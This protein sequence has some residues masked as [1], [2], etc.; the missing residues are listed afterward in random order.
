MTT[1][2][3]THGVALAIDDIIVSVVFFP[4]WVLASS[5]T[6]RR[7]FLTMVR[8]SGDFCYCHSDIKR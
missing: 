3:T 4:F 1:L 5:A 7:S 8:K 2:A 6:L